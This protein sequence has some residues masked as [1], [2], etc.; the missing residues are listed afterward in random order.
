MVK[1][2]RHAEPAQEGL[3]RLLEDKLQIR[4]EFA[5]L[6]GRELRKAVRQAQHSRVDVDNVGSSGS[7]FAEGEQVNDALSGRSHS[8]QGMNRVVSRI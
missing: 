5:A 7:K 1:V 2:H 8:N 3:R 4:Q 6:T